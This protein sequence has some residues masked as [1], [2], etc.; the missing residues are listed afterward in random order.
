MSSTVSI[1]TP[2]RPTFA[3]RARRIRIDPHLRREIERDGQ[4]RLPLLQ[5]QPEPLVRLARRPEAG[6]LAH[7]PEPAA[8]HRRLHAARVREGAGISQI[9]VVLDGRVGRTIDR[10]DRDSRGREARVGDARTSRRRRARSGAR[11]SA[12]RDRRRS[13]SP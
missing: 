11:T 2:T 5:Q 13:S 8:V 3:V 12:A 1:A 6:V 7:C 9:P 4:S 10:R